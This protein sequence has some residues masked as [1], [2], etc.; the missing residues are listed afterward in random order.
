[1]VGVFIRH[2]RICLLVGDLCTLLYC[3]NS[4]DSGAKKH[5]EGIC[6][7]SKSERHSARGT[8][9]RK[10]CLHEGADPALR[11]CALTWPSDNG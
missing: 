6:R 8:E 10:Q 7:V 5:Y 11:T 9:S 2:V 4:N 1:M 3:L